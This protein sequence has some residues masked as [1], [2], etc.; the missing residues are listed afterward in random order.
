M[1]AVFADVAVIIIHKPIWLTAVSPW[2]GVLRGSFVASYANG[3]FS[4]SEAEADCP[5]DGPV[6]A[7]H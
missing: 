4:V 5:A 6:S 7:V 1:T 2:N 3:G